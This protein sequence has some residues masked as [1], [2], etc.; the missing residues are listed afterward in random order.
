[1]LKFFDPE[2][3][4][5]LVNIRIAPEEKFS[6]S[7]AFGTVSVRHLD[8]GPSLLPIYPQGKLPTTGFGLCVWL[9]QLDL[10]GRIVLTGFS[11]KRSERWKVFDVHDWT[12]EQ[13]L[14]RMFSRHGRIDLLEGHISNPYA[15]LHGHFPE[16]SQAEIA[17]TA[18]EVLSD[19][20]LNLSSVVDRLMSV[21]KVLRFFDN[22][23]RKVRPRTRKQ[24]FLDRQKP[25]EK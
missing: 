22:S 18:N 6:P 1:M 7:E 12:F 10:P 9:S 3:F 14:L 16:F 25:E 11:S 8:L 21:T 4:L 5:G 2:N 15:A 17:L 13:V 23:F 19:R 24:R 20:L